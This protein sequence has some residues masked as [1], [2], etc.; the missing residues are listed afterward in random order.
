MNKTRLLQFGLLVFVWLLIW[1]PVAS[2]LTELFLPNADKLQIYLFNKGP[3]AVLLLAVMSKVGGLKFFGMERGSSWWFLVPGLPFLLLT[4]AVFFAPNAAFGLSIPATIGW[5][6]VALSI[7]IGEEC[8]FRGILWRAL[9]PLG[10]L[11][12]AFATSALFGAAHLIGLFTELPW[13]IVISQAIFAFGVGMTLAAVRLVS[14]SLFAPIAL[15][16]VFDA[17][18]ILAAGGVSEMLEDTLTVERLLIPSAVFTVW[19][20][21]CIL[22]VNKRRFKRR[23]AGLPDS[24]AIGMGG[25]DKE[26]KTPA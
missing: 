16:A 23:P 20:L 11:V 8:V 15:H 9:E 26:A 2:S 25:V 22:I 19:G 7:G 14:G 21:V 6:L 10:I 13:Q 5:I 17:G 4:A 24:P 3:F 12:T 18:A 1:G